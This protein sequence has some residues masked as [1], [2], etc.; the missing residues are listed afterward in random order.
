MANR[1]R[2]PATLCGTVRLDHYGGRWESKEFS[3]RITDEQHDQIHGDRWELIQFVKTK[4]KTKAKRPQELPPQWD[5]TLTI[6]YTFGREQT[7][8]QPEF[9]DAEGRALTREELAALKAG[10]KVI[11]TID[12]KPFV[13]DT[14]VGKTVHARVGTTLYVTKVEVVGLERKREQLSP[15]AMHRS[16]TPTNPMERTLSDLVGS[17]VVF[18]LQQLIENY[19]PVVGSEGRNQLIETIRQEANEY[20]DQER[21]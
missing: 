1:Y 11:L 12:Q 6:K 13:F 19:L 9:V 20:L 17:A 18:D 16:M 15:V 3:Y 2:I 10:S 14:Q 5:D 8:R 21:I 7:A 4:T